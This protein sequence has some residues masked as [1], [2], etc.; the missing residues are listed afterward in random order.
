M[1]IEIVFNRPARLLDFMGRLVMWPFRRRLWWMHRK[2]DERI[3]ERPGF[4][5]NLWRL[6]HKPEWQRSAKFS[7]RVWVVSFIVFWPAA[8]HFGHPWWVNLSVTL[9]VDTLA[10]IFHKEWV[11]ARREIDLGRS[12]VLSYT[13]TGITFVANLG[14]AWYLLNDTSLGNAPSKVVMGVA[15]VLINPVVFLFRDK[16][17]LR[18]CSEADKA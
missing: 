6:F 2:L 5:G 11:W 9:L 4:P 13:Y 16:I 14:F 10:Y 1:F 7:A 17:A 8:G 12:A 18:D 15:G 3:L